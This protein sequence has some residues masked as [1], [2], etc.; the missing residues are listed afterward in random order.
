MVVVVRRSS[1][2][3]VGVTHGLLMVIIVLAGFIYLTSLRRDNYI[4]GI[5]LCTHK[6]AGTLLKPEYR[7]NAQLKQKLEQFTIV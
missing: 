3:G 4:Q 6:S 1:G 7:E 2:E 5:C